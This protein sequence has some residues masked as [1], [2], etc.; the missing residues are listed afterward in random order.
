MKNILLFV[1]FLSCTLQ[2]ESQEGTIS[3]SGFISQFVPPSPTNLENGCIETRV[4][5]PEGRRLFDIYLPPG[6]DP[7]DT[8]T[9]Y[10]V[11]YW[12]V[13]YNGTVDTVL[14]RSP[15]ALNNKP[16]LDLFINNGQLMPMIVVY[17][18]PSLAITF[19]L[20]KGCTACPSSSPT[21]RVPGFDPDFA[22][23]GNS[24]YI[25]SEL[26]NVQ[27]ETYFIE[28]LIPFIDTNFNTLADRNFR[29]IM[30]QSMGGYGA[31]L[32]GM[33]NP[34]T[35][36]AFVA[37]SPT[38]PWM[39]TNPELWRN[40]PDYDAFTLNSI[41]IPG[42]LANNGFVSPCNEGYNGTNCAV[43]DLVFALSAALSPNTTGG[44]SFLDV[45]QVNLPIVV[46]ENGKASLVDGTFSV[47][48]F[49]SSSPIDKTVVD[50]SVVLDQS[51]IDI[52]HKNDPF[53]M[54][55]SNLD[56]LAKQAIY[57][58]GGNQ[59]PLNTVASRMVSD[60]LMTYT[61]DNEYILYDGGHTSFIFP[62]CCARNTTGFK[63]C[64]AQ[65]AAAG[66]C[67]EDISSKL[68]GTLTITLCDDAHLNICNGSV[69]SIQTS[70][71][72]PNPD[73][74]ITN[75]NVTFDL[76]D[77][78]AIHVG[79]ATQQGGALQVGDP[80]TKAQLQEF[81]T[82]PPS[83]FANHEVRSSINLH[84][85][86]TLLEIGREGFLGV[87]IGI[88]GRS[89]S[90]IPN[91]PKIANFWSVSSLANLKNITFALDKGVLSH[92][93]I[94]SG[95]Q[96]PASLFGIDLSC[97]YVFTINPA[98]FIIRGGGN[99]I[100]TKLDISNSPII[101]GRAN[102]PPVDRKARLLHPTVLN[103]GT[104]LPN[105][106]FPFFAPDPAAGIINRA[107]F[108]DDVIDPYTDN[109][110]SSSTAYTNFI[111]RGILQSTPLFDRGDVPDPFSITTDSTD[112]LCDFLLT[113]AYIKQPVKLANISPNPDDPMLGFIQERSLIE[114][115]STR[116]S[117]PI[118][119]R[120]QAELP[121]GIDPDLPLDELQAQG[122]IGIQLEY[123]NT[124]GDKPLENI[125]NL[126]RIIRLYDPHTNL[127]PAP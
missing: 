38:P 17:P 116:I 22:S 32:L 53:F 73:N 103:E 62:L 35:F 77:R 98:S 126:K 104:T 81:N 18:D 55:E 101:G 68:M 102:P 27:Y 92:N 105:N 5:Q 14:A 58:D 29:A 1:V 109:P 33:R 78:A 59:E 65:F 123:I 42:I 76:K 34:N 9:R 23:Y 63:M 45:F 64:S 31:L 36:A 8:Q 119:R 40:P 66:V 39:F 96:K 113:K 93:V 87:G 12:C 56:T 84:G 71:T 47:V 75:T 90:N 88:T 3:T 4:T 60:K 110:I 54:I 122:A 49:L 125:F 114:G 20:R 57:L 41:M 118:D 108:R 44:T 120:G 99:M 106:D 124:T 111:K 82:G 52:W 7:N 2:A 19:Q 30:G 48:D 83:S 50:K 61:I 70:R 21:C 117:F 67:I 86:D 95:D 11:V 97:N 37:E 72:I 115:I 15:P 10:P 89:N 25:N 91:A 13:G 100:C 6:Y 79:T 43:N 51:V 26:N 24:F 46:D 69:L 107:D 74:P 94:T 85:A 80:F 127:N 112:S 28:E 121:N 16:L